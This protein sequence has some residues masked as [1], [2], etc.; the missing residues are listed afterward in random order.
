[1]K[2]RSDYSLDEWINLT[3]AKRKTI[4]LEEEKEWYKNNPHDFLVQPKGK[5]VPARKVIKSKLKKL[6]TWYMLWA[7]QMEKWLWG[8][9][10]ARKSKISAKR[11]HDIY[12]K[13]KK[14]TLKEAEKLAKIGNSKWWTAER[15]MYPYKCY[16][17][18]T[19]TGLK[20][21][22]CDPQ[23]TTKEKKRYLKENIDNDLKF[24]GIKYYKS[25]IDNLWK[26]HKAAEEV[27]RINL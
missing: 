16:K 6:D 26:I 2:K 25:E 22:F 10:L 11:F 8:K 18:D 1:M 17:R 20:K 12:E 15:I 7:L 3:P 24:F 19:L 23:V 9:E 13:H 14:I 27:K 4:S 5:S 21:K